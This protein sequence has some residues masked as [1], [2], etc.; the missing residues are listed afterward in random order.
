M[1]AHLTILVYIIII[2]L[3]SSSFSVTIE[4]SETVYDLEKVI[5]KELPNTSWLRPIDSPSTK[6]NL[7]QVWF[8]CLNDYMMI[9][10]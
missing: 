6:S 9:G 5:L 7:L 3:S 1:A 10:E 2:G 8:P 4:S